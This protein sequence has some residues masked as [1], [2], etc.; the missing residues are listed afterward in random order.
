[1]S[2]WINRILAVVVVGLYVWSYLSRFGEVTPP[3]L[4]GPMLLPLTWFVLSVFSPIVG[5]LMVL[6]GDEFA[7]Y[8]CFLSL[9][10]T[11]GIGFGPNS[12]GC[13][14]RIVGWVLLLMPGVVNIVMLRG[15]EAAG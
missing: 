14:V 5:A 10:G 8:F 9:N 15:M 13:L 4:L 6:S 3:P 7:D 2:N 1:M 12:P 11:S